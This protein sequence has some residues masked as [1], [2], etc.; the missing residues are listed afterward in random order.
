M[1]AQAKQV[2][3][4]DNNKLLEENKEF[5][6][7]NE[8]L[9]EDQAALTQELQEAQDTLKKANEERKKWRES[10]VLV[11]QECKQLNLNLTGSKE[12]IKRL[13][14][15]VRELE[16]RVQELVEDGTRN[17]K[18]YKEATFLYFSISGSTTGR[19]T[20]TISPS[21]CKGR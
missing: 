10:A 21:G 19:P 20:L 18:K 2:L 15:R 16:G 6:Q 4:V 17:L 7:L 11:T 5:S 12:E 3:E 9:C 13:E 14:E 1:L 8:Q